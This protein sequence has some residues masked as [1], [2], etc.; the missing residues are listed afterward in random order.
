[1]T[2]SVFHLLKQYQETVSVQLEQV[3]M[4]DLEAYASRARKEETGYDILRSHHSSH[5]SHGS[6]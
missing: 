3:T 2:Y 5:G 4:K 1:M 6:W